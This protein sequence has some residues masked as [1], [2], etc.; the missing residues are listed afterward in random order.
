MIKRFEVLIKG[1]KPKTYNIDGDTIYVGSSDTCHIKIDHPSIS[2]K[3]LKFTIEGERCFIVDEGSTNGTSFGSQRLAEDQKVE[4][5]VQNQV[6]L[7][8][9][10]LLTFLEEPENDSEESTKPH[11]INIPAEAPLE[12]Y[13]DDRTRVISLKEL[14]KAPPDKLIKERSKILKEKSRRKRND[15]SGNKA[16]A[17][18]VMAVLSVFLLGWLYY[19]KSKEIETASAPAPLPV[20]K[21]VKAV[22][23]ATSANLLAESELPKKSAFTDFL[24]YKKCENDL[25]K[26]LCDKIPQ[27]KNFG[28]VQLTNM[29][30]VMIDGSEFIKGAEREIKSYPGESGEQDVKKIAVMRFLQSLPNDLDAELLKDKNL[31]FAFYETSEAESTKEPKFLVSLKGSKLGELK[32]KIKDGH[33]INL[34]KVGG[35]IFRYSDDYI[36]IY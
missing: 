9:L 18:R 28:V 20:R 7:G 32:S 35:I 36:R 11:Q 4:V 16:A 19:E 8:N 33:F 31:T 15:G 26:Y 3:H 30:N 25:E 17:I 13:A 10:V 12:E 34:K 23:S 21:M 29:A 5:K 6:F 24:E 1:Q 22:K 27:T 14:N 2:R